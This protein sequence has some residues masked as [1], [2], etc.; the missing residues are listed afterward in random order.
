[1]GSYGERRAAKHLKRNGYRIICKNFSTDIGEIDIIAKKGETFVFVEVKTRN[2]CDFGR[3]AEA[4]N[5][6]KQRK[7]RMVAMQFFKN[8]C[9]GED[10][11]SRFDVI[12]V[13]EK[14]VNHIENAF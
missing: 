1:M 7:Y 8:I 2:S 11:L 6:D 5:C 13:L 3:P 12:E 4:V 14:Q 9:G 10:R